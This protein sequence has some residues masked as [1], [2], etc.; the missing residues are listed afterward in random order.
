MDNH[1]VEAL[2]EQLG[3][4]RAL[5]TDIADEDFGRSTRCPGWT[6]ADIVAHLD[7]VLIS[8]ASENTQP[9]DGAPEI[10]RF[11]VYLR[12]PDQPSP[13]AQG[14]G[15]ATK[16]VAEA[17][18]DSAT[19]YVGGRRPGQLRTSLQFAIDGA[20]SRF[21]QVPPDRVVMRPPK[22]P[23]MT[24]R[25]LVASRHVEF[26]IHTLDIAQATGRP[27]TLPPASAAIITGILDRML[28]QT[29]PDSLGWDSIR[30]ILAG[31]GRAELE[32]AER[33]ILGQLADRF[34][35]FR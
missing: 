7:G 23:R 20:I 33:E 27:E 16:T 19:K 4:L 29:V 32:P 10:T 6:V 9:V 12:D 21:P 24:Y 1:E 15:T 18:R 17:V 11:D 3:D 35:I 26:G 31:S 5:V 30:Y 28:G 2:I 34:P 25:E 22:Y 8:L 13:Y 14:E